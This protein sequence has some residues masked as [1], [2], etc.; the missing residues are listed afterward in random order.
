M[1]ADFS[2]EARYVFQANS[3]N[4]FSDLYNQSLETARV[5]NLFN[6]WIVLSKTSTLKDNN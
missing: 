6:C 1:L 4:W 3:D 2:D 5:L